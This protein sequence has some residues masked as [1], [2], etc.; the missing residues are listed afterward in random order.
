MTRPV[1]QISHRTFNTSGS[2]KKNG[3]DDEAI[4][5]S[6]ENKDKRRRSRDWQRRLLLGELRTLTPSRRATSLV[7]DD[8]IRQVAIRAARRP[9]SNGKIVNF[10]SVFR[11]YVIALLGKS[12]KTRFDV[13]REYFFRALKQRAMDHGMHEQATPEKKKKNQDDWVLWLEE[14]AVDVSVSLSDQICTLSKKGKKLKDE[15][16]KGRE[17]RLIHVYGERGFQ[18]MMVI[19]E[20]DM[21]VGLKFASAYSRSRDRRFKR[22]ERNRLE[23]RRSRDKG[24]RYSVTR[25]AA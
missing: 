3:G 10:K 18:K 15:L 16:G 2:S 12:N 24:S 7:D 8:L 5:D 14:Q 25:R 1:M 23:L 21:I 19:V 4:G 22:M 13:V 20:G 9:L 17:A 6:K 11:I